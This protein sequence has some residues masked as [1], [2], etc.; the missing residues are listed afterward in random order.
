MK[1]LST[2]AIAAL[3]PVMASAATVNLNSTLGGNAGLLYGSDSGFYLDGNDTDPYESSIVYLTLDAG[4]YNITPTQ[5]LYDSWSRWPMSSGCND[6][7]E[8]CR[9]GYNHTFS[10]FMPETAFYKNDGSRISNNFD[11]ETNPLRTNFVNYAAYLTDL[12]FETGGQ[13]FDSVAG[14]VMASFTLETAQQVG[15]Y[16]HDSVIGDNRGGVSINVGNIA[17]V[18][19]PG[20]FA[21]LGL[22]IA[23][24]A[25][26]RRKAR[27]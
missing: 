15:F 2:C 13:S 10:Y 8:D 1:L 3:L 7:G 18:P 4:T 11:A 16:L 9:R 14:T 26:T 21:L 25:A 5:D 27:G 20:G 23:G 17:P 24:L 19:L 22:G 12:F 6:D